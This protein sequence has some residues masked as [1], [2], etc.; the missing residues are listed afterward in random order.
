MIQLYP[1]CSVL[2]A[3]L[4]TS[5]ELEPK[6]VPQVLLG[7]LLGTWRSAIGH[8]SLSLATN[9]PRSLDES[10]LDPVS[11]SVVKWRICIYFMFATLPKPAP[12][13]P[14][15]LFL[16]LGTDTFF[17]SLK[18]NLPALCSVAAEC[19]SA[20]SVEFWLQTQLLQVT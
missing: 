15:S 2:F 5:G 9:I 18:K 4:E 14:P 10:F 13:T 12:P 7:S 6:C 1:Y 19:V 17:S 3:T 8:F 11:V 16:L 20:F